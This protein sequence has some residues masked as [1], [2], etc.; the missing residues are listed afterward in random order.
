[1]IINDLKLNVT[2]MSNEYVKQICEWHYPDE[3]SEYNI[4]NYDEIIKKEYA[5][6]NPDKKNNY[7]CFILPDNN[8][9]AY[10]NI[11]KRLDETVFIGIGI[12]PEYCG[13]GYGIDILKYGINEAK[14][15]FPLSK[16]RLQVRSWNKRAIKCYEKSGFRNNGITKEI[17]HNGIETEFVNME[18]N[19]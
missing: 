15:R 11:T 10:I 8:L 1:M 6:T 5:I 12:K 16:I 17:D 19:I 14:K 3:Y 13:K 7:L 9:F 2:C 4:P 18:Y